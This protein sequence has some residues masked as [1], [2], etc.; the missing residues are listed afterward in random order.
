[1]ALNMASG[2]YITIHGSDDFSLF[3]RFEILM[4]TI[5]DNKLMNLEK[6]DGIT[7]IFKHLSKK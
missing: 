3:N 7:K 4:K 2:E 5:L 1:M 6:K